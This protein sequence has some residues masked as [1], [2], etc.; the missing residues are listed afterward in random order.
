MEP[1]AVPGIACP[2]PGTPHSEG[3]IVELR[4]KLGLAAGVR[5]QQMI[6][7]ARKAGGDAAVLTGALIETYLLVGVCGWT[8]VNQDGKPVP[9]NEDTIRAHLLDDFDRASPVADQADALYG[10]TVLGPFV[11]P[12]SKPSPATSTAPSTSAK[13]AGSKKPRRPSRSS[14]TSTSQTGVTAT[15]SV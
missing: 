14:S 5:L 15:T 8:F 3:D 13:S 11:V 6:V 4:P 1:I 10:Q 9:V 2:C 12:R 7:E